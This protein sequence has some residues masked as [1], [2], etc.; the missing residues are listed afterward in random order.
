[1][2]QFYT[3]M[4]LSFLFFTAPNE[5]GPTGSSCLH[6]FVFIHVDVDPVYRILD[7]SLQKN[8]TR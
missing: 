5:S 6:D 4:Y 3:H 8:K 1:M 7:N 2:G